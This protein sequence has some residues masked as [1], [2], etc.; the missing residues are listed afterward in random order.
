VAG[1]T[2]NW[3]KVKNPGAPAMRRKPEEDWGG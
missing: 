3:L 1:R 2:N